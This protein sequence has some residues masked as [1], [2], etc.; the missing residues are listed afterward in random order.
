MHM[1]IPQMKELF[2]YC[3]STH[4]IQG[5]LP[6]CSSCILNRAPDL[7]TVPVL[8]SKPAIQK[9]TVLSEYVLSVVYC[10]SEEKYQPHEME[11]HEVHFPYTCSASGTQAQR[12]HIVVL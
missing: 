5:A 1:P 9:I 3:Y 2:R 12:R 10:W 7:C 8:H 4:P 6:A 11:V